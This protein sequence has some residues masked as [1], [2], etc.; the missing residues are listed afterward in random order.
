MSAEDDLTH[1]WRQVQ[2]RL[3]ELET[4]LALM[5]I[6]NGVKS[7]AGWRF[8]MTAEQAMRLRQLVPRHGDACVGISLDGYN[9]FVLDVV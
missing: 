1:S 9:V 6:E 8:E 7:D 5:I 4:W 3:K 2:A